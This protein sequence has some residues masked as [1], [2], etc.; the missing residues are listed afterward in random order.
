MELDPDVI[1]LDAKISRALA[2]VE[3]ADAYKALLTDQRKYSLART[4][5]TLDV[6]A[7]LKDLFGW[8]RPSDVNDDFSSYVCNAETEEGGD[9]LLKDI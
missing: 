9:G 8:P 6:Q 2:L 7:E 5:L 3:A 1:Q 4:G